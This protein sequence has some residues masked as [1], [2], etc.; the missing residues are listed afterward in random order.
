METMKL[1]D[2]QSLRIAELPEDYRVIGVDASA[3]M[4]RKPSGQV[5]RIQQ[6]G[7]L[8]VAT[9]AAKSRLAR[10]RAGEADR[11]I[12]GVQAATPYMSVLG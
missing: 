8:T 9:V 6:N 12:G 4:V 10:R 7:R 2:R 11:V 3:P 1:T 5:M